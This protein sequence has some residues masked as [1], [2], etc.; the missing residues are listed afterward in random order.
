MPARLAPQC[1]SSALTS[2]PSGLP[3]AGWTTMP[4]GLSMTIRC[5]SSKRMSSGIGC[6]AGTGVGRFGQDDDEMLGAG[7]TRAAPGRAAR[8]PSLVTWPSRISCLK[9]LRD[10]SGRWRCKARSRRMPSSAGAML[11]WIC[12]P[13]APEGGAAVGS[14][15]GTPCS[16]SHADRGDA[17]V[18][19]RNSFPVSLRDAPIGRLPRMMI[20]R[21]CAG[22]R[23]EDPRHR[24]GDDARRRFRRLVVVIAGRVSRGGPA[25]APPVACRRA[26]D[27]PPGRPHRGDRRRSRS[28]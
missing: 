6:A 18:D 25:A 8:A 21:A 15:R 12:R 17:V 22:A 19:L 27:M 11:T 4:A 1:A 28:V 2:V 3:G 20:G 23:A 10:S 24:D 5:A 14:L 9:R 16:A 13:S 26:V 7:R